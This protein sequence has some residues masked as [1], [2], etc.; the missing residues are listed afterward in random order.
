MTSGASPF[1]SDSLDSGGSRV[2][3]NSR[4]RCSVRGYF[5]KS[6]VGA[7]CLVNY[8]SALQIRDDAPPA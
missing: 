4:S 5:D 3:S 6:S 2:D 1:D 8:F 7:N